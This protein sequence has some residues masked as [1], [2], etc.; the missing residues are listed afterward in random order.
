[1]IKTHVVPI[2]L[3]TLLPNDH[4]AFGCTYIIYSIYYRNEDASSSISDVD[5]YV[6]IRKSVNSIY[7]I[8][9]VFIRRWEIPAYLH[10]TFL[11][12]VYVHKMT[13]GRVV[14]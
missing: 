8:F 12:E 3:F 13:R 14:G 1:M 6:K 2:F 4:L 11:S 5:L 10:T 9:P 7:N